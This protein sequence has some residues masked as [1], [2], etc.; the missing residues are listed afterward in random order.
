VSGNSGV[1]CSWWSLRNLNQKAWQ[2]FYEFGIFVKLIYD[3]LRNFFFK[4]L[5]NYLNDVIKGCMFEPRFDARK[6]QLVLT[7][8]EKLSASTACRK[9]LPAPSQTGRAFAIFIWS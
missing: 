2:I 8:P 9:R 7:F 6:P 5:T 4:G 1:A 3:Q